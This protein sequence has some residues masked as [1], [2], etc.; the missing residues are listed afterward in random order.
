MRRLR[1]LGA[2]ALML[3]GACASGPRPSLQPLPQT[4][5]GVLRPGDAVRVTV[6]RQDELSGE[7]TVL[8]DGTLAHPLY[9]TVR[10]AGRPVSE[11]QA[12]VGENVG[13]FVTNPQ[14]VVQPL[15][16]VAVEGEVND[17][18]LYQL[19]PETT[20]RQ[21][22][23]MAGGPGERGRLD[24]V[25]LIRGDDA[26]VLDLSSDLGSG[27]ALVQS[28]D[29]LFVPRRRDVL[30]EVVQPMASIV[31]AAAALVN[32]YRSTRPASTAK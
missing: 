11:V 16:Q 24:R 2:L 30:R 26:Y 32:L 14:F 25:R 22:I 6:Y 15:L 17:P 21:A 20:L 10:V 8:G 31:A 23:S 1:V 18:K 5:P 27:R 9:R 7:F 4:G 28:G 29:E 3:A 19:P 12:A 13:R